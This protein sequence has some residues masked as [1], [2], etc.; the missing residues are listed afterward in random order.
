MERAVSET[1]DR[2]YGVKALAADQDGRRLVIEWQDGH[3]SRFPFVWLRH[4]RFFPACGRPDQ[5]DDG[6]YLVPEA[7]DAA[8][9]GAVA[10]D[11]RSVEIH[12]R[13]DEIGRASC[14]E[15]V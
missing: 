5:A 12:W 6:S 4:W 3:I 9:I 14:R 2:R 11:D 13:H 7:S 15:R 1:G 8:V 10:S